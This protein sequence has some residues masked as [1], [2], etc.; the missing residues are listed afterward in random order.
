MEV[1]FRK[2]K[3]ILINE[4]VLVILASAYCG[5]SGGG[6]RSSGWSLRRGVRGCRKAAWMNWAET[7][8]VVVY[9]NLW[10]ALVLHKLG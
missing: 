9:A 4:I 7:E 1:Q 2:Q 5:S 10:L 8:K 3:V 6:A